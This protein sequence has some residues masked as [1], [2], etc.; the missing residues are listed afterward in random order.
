MRRLLPATMIVLTSCAT[1]P[2]PAEPALVGDLAVEG[3]VAHF[4]ASTV[5][6]NDAAAIRQAVRSRCNG[7]CEKVY[8]DVDP[9]ATLEGVRVAVEALS[10]IEPPPR[11]V[12]LP[13][14]AREIE[15]V[16]GGSCAVG[17]EVRENGIWV[18]VDGELA[19]ADAVCREWTATAC[20]AADGRYDW[21]R[22]RTIVSEARRKLSRNA[23]EAICAELHPGATGADVEALHESVA[24]APIQLGDVAVPEARIPE[25][26][27]QRA[28]KRLRGDFDW[29]FQQVEEAAPPSDVR[30]QVMVASD[31]AVTRAAVLEGIRTTTAFER[32]IEDI[33][34]KLE[35]GPLE[36][37]G[38]AV[39]TFEL[40]L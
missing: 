27:V 8:V 24:S 35:F 25:E 17:A 12:L 29:C 28:V 11:L 20:R 7:S 32:C 36:S 16:W 40:P 22:L 18:V 34:E 5:A 37:D 31:G 30:V 33:A 26:T 15:L 19:E 6:Q 38:A 9:G 10:V 14:T 1:A 39:V 4:P 2:E 21:A 13:P 23:P 3:K